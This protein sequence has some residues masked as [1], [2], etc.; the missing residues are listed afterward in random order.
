M[1]D[2]A[3]EQANSAKDIVIRTPCDVLALAA[4]SATEGDIVSALRFRRKAW[5]MAQSIEFVDTFESM[6]YLDVCFSELLHR[7]MKEQRLEQKGYVY[8]LLNKFDG[9]VK[10]GTTANP[11]QRLKALQCSHSQP[12]EILKVV[13][14]GQELEAELHKKFA[15]YR[16][17]G[18]WFKA[19]KTLMSYI[20]KLKQ[21]DYDLTE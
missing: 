19:H 10:I 15:D 17:V 3:A 6:V 18:E 7:C 5:E 14:G 4:K 1:I 9:A 12:L 13:E 16:I 8:F 20:K 11:R 21:V 2:Q